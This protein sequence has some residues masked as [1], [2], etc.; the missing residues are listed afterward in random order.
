[1]IGNTHASGNK[2]KKHSKESKKSM[3]ISHKGV[4][5][6]EKNYF[7]K[8]GISTYERKLWLNSQRRIMRLG[9]G[10]SH[11]LGE[12]EHLKA[13]YQWTCP[14]CKNKEPEITLSRDHITPLSFGGSDNIENIQ[15]LCKSCNSK[16]YNKLIP[17]YK[18]P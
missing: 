15:P 7:W 1:M 6:G 10:G 17:K 13:L 12:W 11:T 18:K 14:A 3:S 9:N 2:G 5:A 8:G 4:H 16:K